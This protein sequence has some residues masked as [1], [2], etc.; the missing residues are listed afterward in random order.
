VDIEYREID[1]LPGYRFGSDGSIESRWVRGSKRRR[2]VE[3]W[4]PV[5]SRVNR[6]LGY[7][8]TT[9]RAPEG[10]RHFRLNVLVLWAFTGHRPPGM[11]ASHLDGN[12]LNNAVGNLAWKSHVGNIR[13]KFA[14]G[15]VHRGSQ[16]RNSKLTEGDIPVIRRLRAEGNTFASLGRAFGV[17]ESAIR[18][19]F[20]RHWRHVAEVA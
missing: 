7:A 6:R 14:H 3:S 9:L 8:Y 18:A 16:I 10:T 15:T 12:R 20:K 19:V 4:H 17:S 2:M 1:E 5:R 13:D 11:E